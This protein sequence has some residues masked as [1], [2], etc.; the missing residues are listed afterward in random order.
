M[1]E[2][3]LDQADFHDASFFHNRHMAADFPDHGHL[4]RDNHNRDAEFPVDLL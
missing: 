2:N 3:L 1:V 4:M